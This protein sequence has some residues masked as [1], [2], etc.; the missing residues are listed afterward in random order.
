MTALS[1]L[2]RLINLMNRAIGNVFMWLSVGI[3]LVCF[4]VVV[5][6]Y[7]FLNTR[8]WMQDLYPWM[9]GVMFTAVAGYALYRNDHVRVDI[10]YRPASTLRKAWLDLLGVCIFL[11]PFAWVVWSYSLVFVQRSIR[12]GEA[13]ANPGGMPG[14]WVLK[15]F[16]LV[17][18][19]VIAL[20]GIA[21]AIRS[22]LIIAGRYDLVPDDY[23]YKYDTET[24]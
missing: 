10:F 11:M 9:N 12:L 13:S 1:Y 16:I 3:V 4:W 24:V 21:M 2:M 17:L 14:L 23:K 6:R 19:V 5:E 20:Q 18:A 22:I 7:V 8:L 15:T